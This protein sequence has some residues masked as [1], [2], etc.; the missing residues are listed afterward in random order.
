MSRG[1]TNP[2][3][4]SIASTNIVHSLIFSQHSAGF[5]LRCASTTVSPKGL[6]R[7]LPR[8]R[9][10]RKRKALGVE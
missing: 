4:L 6:G 2:Q 5:G 10:A 7:P 1:K 9:H 8:P 3:P